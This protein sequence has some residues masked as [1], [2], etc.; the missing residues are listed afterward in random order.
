L[1]RSKILQ[2]TSKRLRLFIIFA[3]TSIQAIVAE[4]SY[5]LDFI[6][7]NANTGQSSGGHSAIR[8]G[9]LIYHFQFFPDKIFHIVRE[10]WN[11]FR[12]VYGIQEN[13][14]IRI[15]PIQVSSETY[16][17][18][19]ERMN[20]LYL[21]QQ[22]ELENLV[23]LKND[24]LIIESVV[25]GDGL[26]NLKGLGYFSNHNQE[27]EN[28]RLLISKI[29]NQYG[30]K[31]ILENLILIRKQIY[32]FRF[33][34]TETIQSFDNHKTLPVVKNFSDEYLDLL[35]RLKAFEI[36]Y[37]NKSLNQ[38]SL[39]QYEPS[40]SEDEK[41]NAFKNLE[42]IKNQ[43]ENDIISL[44][45]NTENSGYVLLIKIARYL[46][47][48]KSLREN[49]FYFLDSFGKNHSLLSLKVDK[50]KN[51]LYTK[52]REMNQ[53][54]DSTFKSRFAEKELK[55]LSEI[56]YT[57]IEDLLSRKNEFLEGILTTKPI[58]IRYEIMLPTKEESIYI[59]KDENQKINLEEL[60]L[61][62]KRNAFNYERQLQLKYPFH[63]ISQNCTTEIF[64]SLNSFYKNKEDVTNSLG[65]Y[66]DKKD[67]FVFIPFYAYTKVKDSYRVND[68][69]EVPSFR[70]YI[71]SKKDTSNLLLK[72]KE[73]NTLTSRYYKFN[74][75]DSLFLFFTDDSIWIRPLFGF[76]NLIFGVGEFSFGILT[77]PLDSGEKLIKGLQ[78]IFFSL[79]EMIFFN[80]RKGT[81]LYETNF[82]ENN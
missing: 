79:P 38:E 61:N 46:T 3:F 56:E 10:E 4:P 9:N 2:T 74:K 52:L 12:F 49:K 34:E 1:S 28:Y 5:F 44:I 15:L 8:L 82:I 77:F 7:V 33:P 54:I 40:L 55:N 42:K 20:F 27:K 71:L 18:I 48:L 67:S 24:E 58:R 63:I 64:H 80:I 13:R 53:R 30:S 66:I 45:R 39:I 22:K 43:Y 75:E 31:Y 72:I 41:L 25:K 36:L 23:K 14:T 76:I 57:Q 62:Y 21:Y 78:G 60:L 65:G 29:E 81:F 19:L 26:I 17:Y 69:I 47:I 35:S 68:G 11:S 50:D 6:Y 73:S 16:N 32:S 70:T 51:L 59:Y 37:E